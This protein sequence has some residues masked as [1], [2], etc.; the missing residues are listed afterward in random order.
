MEL[1]MK[2]IVGSITLNSYQVITEGDEPIAPI[3]S[4]D[5][6]RQGGVAIVISQPKDNPMLVEQSRAE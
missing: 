1:S 4:S 2:Q 6:H 3:L 5:A